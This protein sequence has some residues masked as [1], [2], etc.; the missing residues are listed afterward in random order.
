MNALFQN[1]N[2][3]SSSNLLKKFQNLNI[4]NY[5]LFTKINNNQNQNQSDINFQQKYNLFLNK[6]KIN[7]LAQNLNDLDLLYIKE[8][9][10][11][12]IINDDTKYSLN[13]NKNMNNQELNNDKKIFDSL[14]EVKKFKTELCHSWELTGTCKYGLNVS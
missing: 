5:Y 2:I 8:R 13:E 3:I 7:Q 4:K 12:I 6:E 14:S 10:N 9:Q 1:L 11:K